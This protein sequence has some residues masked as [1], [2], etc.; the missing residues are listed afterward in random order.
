MAALEKEKREQAPA[1]PHAVIYSVKYSVK[2]RK[3]KENLGD[4]LGEM[5]RSM[6]RPYIY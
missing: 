4:G 3:V 5:G 1:L 2:S 6:L